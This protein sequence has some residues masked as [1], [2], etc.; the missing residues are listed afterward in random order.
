MSQA[1]ASIALRRFAQKAPRSKT[2]GGLPRN[3]S[4]SATAS[5]V[6][7]C[8]GRNVGTIDTNGKCQ[9][10]RERSSQCNGNRRYMTS[11]P[12]DPAPL[13][14]DLNNSHDRLDSNMDGNINM[15]TAQ[16]M[17]F[18]DALTDDY[19]Y[20]PAESN[21]EPS[22][23]EVEE[24]EEMKRQAVRDEIDSRKGRLWTDRWELTDDDWAS[25]K[26]LDD[27]PDWTEEICSRVSRERVQVH[28]G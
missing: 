19:N 18:Y 20:Y 10:Q 24:M 6:T 21:D 5:T 15:K 23:D 12:R 4:I 8:T 22:S 28:P 1:V 14:G 9:N 13:L 26:V 11:K 17:E 25:G 27:L 16:D 3:Y 7:P 2:L